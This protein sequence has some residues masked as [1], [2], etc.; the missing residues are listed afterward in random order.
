[1]EIVKISYLGLAPEYQQ[2]AADETSLITT[3]TI[4]SN[5]GLSTDYV[6][7]FIRDLNDTI[8]AQSYNAQ[9]YI[10][11][12]NITNNLAS[13]VTSVDL[14]PE[15]DVRSN[16]LDRGTTKIKY[17]F[18]RKLLSSGPAENYWI[19][20]ISTSRTE[21]KVGRQDLSNSDLLNA[22]NTF[23]GGVTS[24]NYYYDFLLNFGQDV[25]II[26]T[27]LAYIEE[28]DNA[29]L[30]IK[31]YDP[32]P[33]EYD[34]Y[35]QF[36]VVQKAADSVQF[37]VSIEVQADNV[38]EVN[39]LRGPNYKVAINQ[40]QNQTTPYYNYTS[41]FSTSVTSSYQQLQ[42]W[43]DDKAISINVDYSDFSNYI[44]FSSATERLLNFQYKVGLIEAYQSDIAASNAVTNTP[45]SIIAATNASLQQKI[46][47]II[48]RFDGYEYYLYFE[49]ASTAWP[50]QN[51]IKPYQLYS[52]T[53]SVVLDWLGGTEVAPSTGKLSMLYSSSLYDNLNKDNIQYSMP[54]YIKEDGNNQP[55]TTFLN[56]IGQHFDNI[57]IYYKDVSNR[58]SAENNPNVGI[59]M[60]VVAD[61]L[62]GF[63]IQLYTNSN[64]SDNIYYSMLGLNDVGSTLPL[65]SSQ[66]A[67]LSLS[68]SNLTPLPGNE[69]LSASI[70]LPP[71]SSEN[72][73]EYVTTFLTPSTGV[74]ASFDIISP[75]QLEKEYYKRLYHNL[76]YLL[77]TRGTQRGVKA[78]IACYGIPNSILTV[79]EFGGG[80]IFAAPGL[81]QLQNQKVFTGSTQQINSTLLS[82]YT[83]LQYYQNNLER[84]SADVEVG[85]SP[86]DSINADI[87]SS[88]G[89]F[90]I[91]QYMGNP[92]LQYS[93]SYTPLDTL[94]NN[95]F[96]ANYNSRY[97]VW[98]FI[99]IIKFYNNSL[100]KSIKDYVPAR[101]SVSSAIIVKPH[102]LERNKYARREPVITRPEYSQSIDTA[103]IS[104]SDAPGIDRSTA[105][106]SVAYFASGTVVI[107]ND[108]HWEPYTGEFSGSIIDTTTGYFPQI[109]Q[110]SIT[111]PWTSSVAGATVMYTTYSLNYLYQNVSSSV[112]SLRYLNLDYSTDP[113]VPVNYGLIT[114]SIN[115]YPASL[116]DPYAPWAELQDY[117]YNLRR[118]ILPRYS[119]S[120]S[121]SRLY[122]VYTPESGRYRGDQSYGLNPAIDYNTFK[123]GWVKTIPTESLNFYDKT[124]INL[125]Y[126]VDPEQNVTE[127]SANNDN[128]V[129]VQNTFKSG[130]PVKVSVTDVQFPSNQTI[131]DGTKTIYRGGYRFDPIIYRE[132]NETLTF[133]FEEP[134][135]STLAYLGAKVRTDDYYEY[136]YYRNRYWGSGL[137]PVQI[138]TNPSI[139]YLYKKNG[140]DQSPIP[141]S[142]RFITESDW[143]IYL[144]QYA[145]DTRVNF[146]FPIVQPRASVNVRTVYPFSFLQFNTVVSNTETELSTVNTVPN[147]TYL[148]KVE[149]TSNYNTKINIPFIIQATD[150][151][152]HSAGAGI[153]LFAVLESTQDPT[154]AASWKPVPATNRIGGGIVATEIVPTNTP[155]YNNIT[156]NTTANALI[157][158]YRPVVS[159]LTGRL[160]LDL[161]FDASRGDYLR[162]TV[163]FLDYTSIFTSQNGLYDLVLK[164]NVP[165]FDL[166]TG[167]LYTSAEKA[168][169]EIRDLNTQYNVYTY[170]ASYNDAQG[171]IFTT[172]SGYP[173]ALQLN[174]TAANIFTSAS[175]FQPE[176][177][178]NKYYTPVID[179]MSIEKYDLIR[180]S[181]FNTSRPKYYTV[182]AVENRARP[183]ISLV[184]SFVQQA[185][186]G[187]GV[188][189]D[190]FTTTYNILTSQPPVFYQGDVVTITGTT[191]GVNDSTNVIITG[192]R[193]RFLSAFNST[194]GVLTL[195]FGNLS[196]VPTNPSSATFTF[197]GITDKLIFLDRNLPNDVNASS[198]AILRPKADETTVIIEGRKQ[199]GEVAQTLLIP[200]NASKLLKDNV[201][202]I[203]Q[204]LNVPLG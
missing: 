139:D 86:A 61:A 75:M 80:N 84:G 141:F 92:T 1:M 78:L 120:T 190:Y 57:W 117:N 154:D 71:F 99:R 20:E 145:N 134:V 82:P 165:D 144:G 9:Q 199:V 188:V 203:F 191:G 100:F 119:G 2:Y 63:G 105:Y 104:A 97:N 69:W 196:V 158:G 195:Y 23:N 116:N 174:A 19:K 28:D 91:M 41:L 13:T 70:Y 204:S 166:S 16:G 77:K 198:F 83:T 175:I 26:G 73:N 65:T 101:A 150:T 17:N 102:I 31:L 21:I 43:F 4:V 103:F 48:T 74:T 137:N 36:W 182:V 170:T 112:K 183:P 53:S 121:I 146:T 60:D 24:T 194:I 133:E 46:D 3:S 161:N 54:A 110:S 184:G 123:L 10:P 189:Y 125:K 177:P 171:P 94:S 130:T 88:L 47:D 151:D 50:K 164:I 118:S 40:K 44:H 72:L 76:A 157:F 67:Q 180:F 179:Y 136:N 122:N 187:S 109:E 178:A 59:S 163:Y 52:T 89:N 39:R 15:K 42:S 64:I 34:V 131:L 8:V 140:E 143:L 135:S 35:S 124:I 45:P 153:K 197:G 201:G 173:D 132:A 68:N 56:M 155:T 126:L 149:R 107:N 176:F 27:N 156:A 95:Y 200:D 129:E 193:N 85:F 168:S 167:T 33:T 25:Q 14:D 115:N 62:R 66:Y 172:S 113:N 81:Q 30:I 93:S 37:E 98:D 108:Y 51:N 160:S 90:N 29:Y 138:F 159:P 127:L 22:F 18:F 152:D 55:Y 142:T 5:F 111:A 11:S 49:S 148:Y 128:V 202:T 181:K 106:Q 185:V 38:V 114:E 79:N 96:A 32:L 7:Y 6:E 162:V 12:L 87:S 58:Y 192:V 186:Q 169:F 147:A